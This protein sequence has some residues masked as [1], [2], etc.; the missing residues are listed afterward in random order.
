MVEATEG[1]ENEFAM[2]EVPLDESKSPQSRRS[3]GR[4]DDK[5]GW[6]EDW[7]DEWEGGDPLQETAPHQ[8]LAASR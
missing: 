6:D 1:G 4:G 2:P 8:P 5:D 3:Q 7:G